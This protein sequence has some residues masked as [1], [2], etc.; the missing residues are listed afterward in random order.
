MKRHLSLLA[1]APLRN[2][3]Y[4]QACLLGRQRRAEEALAAL[5]AGLD[6]GSWYNPEALVTEPGLVDVRPL[7]DPIVQECKDR[8]SRRRAETRPLCLVLSPSTTLWD[9]QTVL[10]LHGRADSA[11][12]F[13]EPWRALVD[14]GWTLVVPQSSQP[15]DSESWCWDDEDR[16]RREILTHLDECRMKRGLD[17]ARMV[18]A[19]ASDG[20]RRAVEIGHE[21]GI[22]WLCVIPTFPAGYDAAP[23]ASVPRH[24]RGV[25]LIGENDPENV[26]SRP[27]LSALQGAGAS[28]EVRTMPGVGHELPPDFAVRASEALGLL[29]LG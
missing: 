3:W 2:S 27:V 14:E 13:A 5:R 7:L 23:L 22:P 11:R 21:A 25:F 17:P 18:A 24:T 29:E 28:V 26:W 6:E 20:A 8:R 1:I 4:A 12:H 9:Q 16:A 19:G 10:L 15:W